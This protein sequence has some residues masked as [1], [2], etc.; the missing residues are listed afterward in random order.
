[1][2]KLTLSKVTKIQI[3]EL[4][5]LA[6]HRIQ[7]NSDAHHNKTRTSKIGAISKPQKPFQKMPRTYL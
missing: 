5:Q 7:E 2:K 3:S 6:V 1:M 4:R